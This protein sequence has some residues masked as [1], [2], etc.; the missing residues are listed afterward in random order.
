MAIPNP[1]TCRDLVELVTDYLEG[2]MTPTDRARFDQH[3]AMCD[4]CRNHFE[5]MKTTIRLTGRLTE[6][7]ITPEAERDLLKIFRNWKN[8]AL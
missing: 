2:S 6:D 7:R 5:Q 1:F 8:G 3:L 4:G